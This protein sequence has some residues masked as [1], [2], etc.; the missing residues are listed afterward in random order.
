MSE[1][2]PSALAQRLAQ[3]HDLDLSRLSGSGPNGR[4]TARDVLEHLHNLEP[5]S[6]DYVT[7]QHSAESRTEGDLATQV[8]E[9]TV[10]QPATF[11]PSEMTSEI[12]EATKPENQTQPDAEAPP[13]VPR[14]MFWRH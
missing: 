11:Q 9:T 1:A 5:S 4:V 7:E 14:W 10:L 12:L 2:N 3:A 13:Q 8:Q 6:R